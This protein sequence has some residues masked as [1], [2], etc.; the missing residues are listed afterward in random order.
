[1]S[2]LWHE[3]DGNHWESLSVA[4]DSPLEG[5]TLGAPGI[6]L[7]RFG[8]GP[9]RGV[10][11]MARSGVSVLVNGLPFAGG[12]RLLEHKDEVVVGRRRF[13]YSSESVPVVAIFSAA[14][15]ARATTC[16]ICRGVIKDGMQ[17]VRCPACTRWFHQIE[18]VG[19]QPARRCWSF[20]PTCRICSHPTALNG[21]PVWRPEAEEQRG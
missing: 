17:A 9:D 7:L 21:G 5:D 2:I 19:D 16:P 3:A 12:M 20:A 6:R 18:A 11:L 4:E 14:P 10:A 8:S 1:M 13:F 15:G